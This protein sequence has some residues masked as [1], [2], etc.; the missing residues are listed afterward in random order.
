MTQ[1]YPLQNRAGKHLVLR[2]KRKAI[3]AMP[4]EKA[5]DEILSAPLPAELVQSFSEQ[6]LY[7]LVHDIG[8][9]DALPVLALAHSDQWGYMIDV[10]TWTRDRMETDAVTHWFKVLFLAD[11]KRLV[12]WLITE[13]PAFLELYLFRNIEVIIR[14]ENQDPSEFPDGFFTVDDY[15]YIRIKEKPDPLIVREGDEPVRQEEL[16]EVIHALIDQI[17]ELDY[18]LY[19]AIM[20]EAVSVIPAETEEEHFRLRNVRLAEKGFLPF[21]EAMEIYSP[22]SPDRLEPVRPQKPTCKAFEPEGVTAPIAPAQAISDPNLFTESLERWEGRWDLEDL[23]LEFAS[24]CN[25][26]IAADQTII[27]SRETLAHIAK[28]ASYTISLGMEVLLEGQGDV[29]DASRCGLIDRYAMKQLFRVGIGRIMGLKHRAGRL[30]RDSW[31]GRNDLKLAFWGEAGLGVLGGLLVDKPVYY[32]NYTAGSLYRDF[33]SLADILATE[34]RLDDITGYDELLS[35]MA[36]RLDAFSGYRLTV[37]RLLLTLWVHASSGKPEHTEG[38]VPMTDV[39]AWFDRLWTPGPRGVDRGLGRIRDEEKQAMLTWLALR[40][41]FTEE[42]IS[43][44][45][46]STLEALFRN[47][48]SEYGTVQAGD[49]DARYL[50]HLCIAPD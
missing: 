15:F 10:E 3:M 13:R 11:G 32:D 17:L 5:L 37:D 34:R 48:E 14:E 49:L 27:R 35:M 24:L 45:M 50:V 6:D 23:E 33:Q 7:L 1:E 36:P 40:T 31:F 12:R 9:S 25:Q 38:P 19:Q 21:D 29:D 41:G 18:T 16:D 44:R 47:L 22:L 42:E 8:L 4:P 26:M 43:R 46:G 30:V 2:D 39:R 20:L 28:K